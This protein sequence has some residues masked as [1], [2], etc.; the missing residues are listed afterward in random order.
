MAWGGGVQ[1]QRIIIDT[2]Q[3]KSNSSLHIKDHPA[4]IR[5]MSIALIIL[6]MIRIFKGRRKGTSSFQL[7]RSRLYA[8]LVFLQ[9]CMC[10]T[11][12]NLKIKRKIR[13]HSHGPSGLKRFLI[14][15]QVNQIKNAPPKNNFQICLKIK[16][17]PVLSQT[18]PKH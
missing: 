17:P 13:K 18:H 4:T 10:K 8:Y 6:Q 11:K 12:T 14:S 5:A 7:P 3:F 15:Q 1:N 9:E 16:I 2:Y